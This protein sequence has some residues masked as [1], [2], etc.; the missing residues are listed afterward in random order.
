MR[1]G[2][3]DGRRARREHVPGAGVVGEV[4]RGRTPEK[5]LVNGHAPSLRHTDDSG[6]APGTYAPAGAG[7]PAAGWPWPRG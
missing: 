2:D 7:A 1:G 6:P 3:V 5:V 4:S